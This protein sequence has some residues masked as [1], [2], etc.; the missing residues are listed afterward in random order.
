M[1]I[2]EK[3]Y[4]DSLAG[5]LQDFDERLLFGSWNV[6]QQRLLQRLDRRVQFL[7]SLRSPAGYRDQEHPPV[8][9]GLP[10]VDQSPGG[11]TIDHTRDRRATWIIRSAT[12]GHGIA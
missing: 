4:A 11:Q 3:L 1:Q 10:L 6:A 9:S 5:Q 2:D 8:E 12:S 7:Q